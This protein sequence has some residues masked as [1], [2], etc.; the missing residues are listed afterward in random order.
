[1]VLYNY[2]LCLVLGVCLWVDRLIRKGSKMKKHIGNLEITEK[3]QNDFKDIVEVTGYLHV[4]SSAKLAALTTVGGY[5]HVYSSAK[6]EALKLEALTTIGGSLD[7]SGTEKLEA[8]LL[9][10]IGGSLR[11]SGSA[12]FE[13][14]TTVGGDVRV[15]GS[16][17]FE[18]LTTVGGD[19]SVY[20]SAKFDAPKL[21]TVGGYVSVYN[22]AKFDAPKLTTVG[23]YV[24]VD[25]TANLDAPKLENKNNTSAKEIAARALSLSFS[26]RGLIKIDG[27]L[28]WLISEK[29]IGNVTV[30][31]IK[32]VGKLNNSYA[33][34]RGDV[35]SHGETIEKAIADLRYKISSR[36]TSEFKDW[37]V[38]AKRTSDYC[39][40]AYRV[41]TGACE[42]GVRDFCKSMDLEKKYSLQE[43]FKI[44]EGKFG[45][46]EF[47]KFFKGSNKCK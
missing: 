6:L 41:I 31:E 25:S 11:I 32:I 3:N 47:V 10:T 24:R 43:I 14:L 20:N 8:P 40:K 36:D 34:K 12:K 42:Q 22:S 18:A 38:S 7:V 27:I 45:S 17:K 46:Q 39:I 33:V 13:A 19:V 21:T 2:I 15:S 4:Y 28:S 1:M 44:T 26:L 16:A 35:Y 29:T 30:Y 5:L 37:N 23:G 9:T